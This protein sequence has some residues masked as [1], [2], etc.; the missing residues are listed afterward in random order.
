MPSVP[1]LQ[2]VDNGRPILADGA[3]GTLLHLHG[4][5]MTTCFDAVNLS[6][7]HRVYEVHAAYLAAGA[8]MIETNTF[9]ANRLKLAEHGL[10]DKVAEINA[11]AVE[12]ARRAIA[13]SGRDAYVVGSVGPLG[14]PMRPYGALSK[15]DARNAFY[16]QIAALAEAGVDAILLETFADHHELLEALGAAR[17]AA[18]TIPVIAQATFASDDRTLTGFTPAKVAYDLF[19]A[20]ADVVGVNCS[21]GPSQISNILETM[22][23]C[24]PQARLSAMPNAGY[25]EAVGGR[26]MYPAS[27][28]YFGDYAL[29]LQA[30]GARIV[31]GCCGS[32]PEHIAAMRRALDDAAEGRRKLPFV[33]SIELINGERETPP[34]SDGPTDLA[35]RLA[36]RRFTVTVEMRPPR[37]FS[38]EKLLRSARLLRD[39]G[40]HMLDIADTPAAQMRMSPYAAAHLVQTQVGVETV[41]HFPT[42]GRNL[43]RIQGDLLAAHAM[44]LR[45]VFVTMGDPVKIGDYPHANDSYDIVPSKLIALIKH[46]MNKGVDQAGNS[47]GAPATFMV[48][49]ALNMGADDLDH[50]IKVLGNK[51][52]AGA[53]FA[54]GQAVFEPERI[55]RFL[56]RY[57]EITGE[58]FNLP[59]LLG[60]MPLFS[61]KHANFLNNE[62]PGITIPQHILKRIEDA[63]EDAAQEG[64]KIAQELMHATMG[65]VAGAYILPA[66]GRYDLAAEV[67]ASL[68]VTA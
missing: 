11:A 48:G 43:L 66:F 22:R 46:S 31:G 1:F 47:I 15:E 54:L 45:N 6:D 5:P 36:E 7:P 14:Q 67:V 55:E 34:V 65:M 56:R 68:P 57:E 28:E 3:I 16:E 26:V 33:G 53:D 32:S 51:L 40:A 62:I 18:P 13:D 50:E 29:T 61:L 8:D 59:V 37:S 19:R 52:E 35:E 12:I 38:V 39:A 25:P 44:G 2:R 30:T 24:V 42:R 20:G 41:L 64:V 27:A 10:E 23:V 63:G 9:G 49:C 4:L 58:T 60:V 17:S 21:G